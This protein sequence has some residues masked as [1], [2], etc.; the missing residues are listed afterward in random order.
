MLW[1]SLSCGFSLSGF[2]FTCVFY[3][4]VYIPA[5]HIHKVLEFHKNSLRFPSYEEVQTELKVRI[6]W[7]IPFTLVHELLSFRGA[8][9]RRFCHRLVICEMELMQCSN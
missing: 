6:F 5:K 2:T 4:C 9:C 7:V 1:F 8:R 3:I